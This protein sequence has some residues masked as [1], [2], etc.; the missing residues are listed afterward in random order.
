MTTDTIE[1]PRK[2][3][4]AQHHLAL[5]ESLGVDLAVELEAFDAYN[6]TRIVH[7]PD[8]ALSG[9]IRRATQREAKPAQ[10]PK[11]ESPKIPTDPEEFTRFRIQQFRESN[12]REHDRLLAYLQGHKWWGSLSERFQREE[13][14]EAIKNR[15]IIFN[16]LASQGRRV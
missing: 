1:T 13:L 12:P 5:A 10:L 6:Q 11:P 16:Y 9:W 4:P 8:R 7:D 15:D 14:R 3:K 2:F